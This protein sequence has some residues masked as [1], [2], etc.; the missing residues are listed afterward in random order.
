[1]NV[2]VTGAFGLLGRPC[3]RSLVEAGHRVRAFDLRTAASRKAA[4]AFDSG[5]RIEI[6]WG[7]VRREEDVRRAAEGCEAAVHLAFVLP[8]RCE[9]QPRLSHAVNVEGSRKLLEALRPLP[10]PPKI[11]FASTFC[12]FG[13]TQRLEPPVAPGSPAR[14]YNHY[15][16]H[17]IAVEEMIGRSGLPFAVLRFGIVLAPRMDG[18]IDPIIFDFSTTTRVEFIHCDDAALAVARCL[19][20]DEVWGKTLLVG[21]GKRGQ[22][23][24][25]EMLN[26]TLEAMGIGRLPD[27][28]FGPRA[29]HGG[30]WMDTSESQ[31]ILSYQR[32]S[33]ADYLG[34]VRSSAG[35]RR[36]LL[37][38]LGP[39]ARA[40]ILRKSPYY[41]KRSS[42]ARKS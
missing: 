7:D 15:T 34:H 2:L 23:T 21:A 20:S 5:G 36:H 16:R 31:R 39:L 6:L 42:S 10:G 38:L 37:R 25:G 29:L 14:P 27:E 11:I 1:M 13:D 24:Y 30:D 33:F 9:D 8:P 41:R 18:G 4:R 32:Y 26:G 17:K 28:A 40:M 3:L 19:A 35:A 22:I 12:V